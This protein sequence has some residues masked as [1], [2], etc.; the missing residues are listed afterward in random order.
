MMRTQVSSQYHES[1]SIHT[2][3]SYNIIDQDDVRARDRDPRVPYALPTRCSFFVSDNMF[4][5]IHTILETI[6]K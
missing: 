3:T 4:T 1:A 2:V 5:T 6:Y